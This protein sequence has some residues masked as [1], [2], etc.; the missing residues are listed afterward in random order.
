MHPCS[1]HWHL[2]DYVIVRNKD[3]QD[4][5]VTKAMCGAECWTDHRLIVSKVKLQIQPKRRPQGVPAPKRLNVIRLKSED[6]RSEFVSALEE[7]LDSLL[8]DHQT[9]DTAWSSL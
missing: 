5:L 9:V 4:V 8:L 2:I 3:R 6:T 7:R 1:K